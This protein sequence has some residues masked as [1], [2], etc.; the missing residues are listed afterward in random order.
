EQRIAIARAYLSKRPIVMLDEPTAHLD[1]ETEAEI[2]AAM[3]ELFQGKLVFLATHRLHWMTD[4]D[5]IFVLNQ[6]EIIEK[7]SHEQLMSLQS[8]YYKFVLGQEGE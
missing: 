2:K 4:M 6:G 1:I 8:I 3:L 7:G 5:E